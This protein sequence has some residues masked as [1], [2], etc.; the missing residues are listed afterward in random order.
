MH[1]L[2]IAVDDHDTRRRILPL[3]VSLT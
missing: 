2:K 1:A 3:H